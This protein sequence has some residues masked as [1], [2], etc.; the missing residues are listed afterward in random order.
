MNR[1]LPIL[2]VPL[3]LLLTGCPAAEAPD[4]EADAPQ[5]S[6]A[7]TGAGPS[8]PAP[9]P[10]PDAPEASLTE[11]GV[12]YGCKTDADCE[13]KNIGNCCGYYPACVNRESPTFPD[14]VKA[15]C[16]A[17]G[18]SSICGFPEIAGCE[19]IEGR[20]SNRSGAVSGAELQ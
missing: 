16:A 12:F 3:L 13:V 4:R 18:T 17:Q 5:P 15:D 20:C 19:C 7:E 8:A 11:G 1:L 2:L 6:R 10:A 9:E 14:R